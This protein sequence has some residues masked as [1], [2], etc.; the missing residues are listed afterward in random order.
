MKSGT[1]I[2]AQVIAALTSHK[3][4]FQYG[5]YSVRISKTSV[6]EV[7]DIYNMFHIH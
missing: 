1:E 3:I 2:E 4:S 5:F 7:N 6:D